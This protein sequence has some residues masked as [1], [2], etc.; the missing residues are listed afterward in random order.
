MSKIVVYWSMT[1]NTESIARKI[2]ADVNAKLKEVSEVTFEEVLENDVII[3]GC[4]AMGSEELDEDTFKPFSDELL[5]RLTSQKIFMFGSY[6]WG[7]GQ[8]MRDWIS[9]YKKANVNVCEEGLIVNG[10]DSAIEED[11]YQDFI[12]KING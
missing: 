2:A 1:G 7:D 5:T 8:W 3:L 6:G 4:P 12:N 11:K 9:D 10:D